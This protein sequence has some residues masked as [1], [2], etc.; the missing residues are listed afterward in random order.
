MVTYQ[1]STFDITKFKPT[2]HFEERALERFGITAMQ[3]TKF[4]KDNTPTNN[5]QL[6]AYNNRIQT[7]SKNGIMFVLN[8][9]SKEIITTYKSISPKIA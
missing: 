2:K 1:D 3:M 4:L 6:A 5:V 8:P 7:I 9:D